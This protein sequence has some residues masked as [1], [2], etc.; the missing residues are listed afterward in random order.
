MTVIKILIIC[1]LI[2][3]IFIWLLFLGS[4]H[5]VDIGTHISFALI[6]IL[7]LFILF[8]FNAKKK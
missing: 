1:F 2:L 3:S 6:I 7:L 8:V 5:N 4:S